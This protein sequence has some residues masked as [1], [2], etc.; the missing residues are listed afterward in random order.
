MTLE[1]FY[2][3]EVLHAGQMAYAGLFLAWTLGMVAGALR[4][5]PRVPTNVVGACALV[6]LGIQGAGMGLQT[7]WTVLPVAIVGYAIGGVGH[8]VKNTLLRTLIQCRVPDRVHG[9]AF[10][11][12][13]A[14]RNTAEVAALAGGGLL[15]TAIGARAGLAIAGL[16][17]VLAATAG[18][19]ALRRGTR[20]GPARAPER[21]PVP[22]NDPLPEVH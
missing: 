1:V 15:V 7:A 16:G 18:L 8:G 13:N 9:R 21:F 14:A 3:K 4:L 22:P 20:A 19:V 17:P 12:Y 10:A 5:A 11:A 6:A 2:I